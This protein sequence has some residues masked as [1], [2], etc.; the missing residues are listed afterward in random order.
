MNKVL[1]D[2]KSLEL[3]SKVIPLFDTGVNSVN[4]VEL[5]KDAVDMPVGFE[6][7]LSVIPEGVSLTLPGGSIFIKKCRGTFISMR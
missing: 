1:N 3:L 4:L 7:V 6:N 2:K 5:H